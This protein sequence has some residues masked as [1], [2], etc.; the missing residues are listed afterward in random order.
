M[1]AGAVLQQQAA[2]SLLPSGGVVAPP[3]A[4]PWSEW[5]AATIGSI[6]GSPVWNVEANWPLVY[7]ALAAHE[8]ADRDVQIAALAT[9]GV[10]SG[11]FKPIPEWATGDE[12][13]GRADLGN[14][15]PGDG[16][17]YK[18]RGYIQITGR[19][20]YRTYGRL[21]GVDLEGNP[22]LALDPTIAA[23]IFAA[24]FEHHRIRWYKAP[25]PVMNV[26]ELARAQ[27]WRGVRVAVNGGENGL[28]LFMQSVTGLQAA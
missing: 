26:A 15:Y 27:E 25:A 12:Y 13:E 20:N 28:G 21:L 24:Y 11:S 23:L 16:R 4:G 8:L 7:A 19:D 10:E 14:V 1:T 2:S 6:L 17:R 18:G 9:I 5:S 22:D 3:G